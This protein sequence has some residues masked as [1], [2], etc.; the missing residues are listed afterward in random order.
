MPQHKIPVLAGRGYKGS[1]KTIERISRFI[2]EV[3][4]DS[5]P[6][7]V[8]IV[9]PDD[10]GATVKAMG[11]SDTHDGFTAAGRTYLNGSI[12]QLDR[13]A[14][15][16]KTLDTPANNYL[17]ELTV[18]HELAHLNDTEHSP[19]WQEQNDIQYSDRGQKILADWQKNRGPE[20]ANYNLQDQA[21]QRQGGVQ[22]TS[23]PIQTQL[24]AAP[25]RNQFS[26]VPYAIARNARQKP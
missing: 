11:A 5:K 19:K 12:F 7:A 22:P 17:P 26:N 2:N 9:N 1:P 20:D 16:A 18:A 21:A 3:P 24:T 8:V 14:E 23:A 15:L 25:I 10:W 4:V 13:A 6:S